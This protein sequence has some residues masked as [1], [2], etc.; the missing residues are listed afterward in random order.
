MKQITINLYSFEELSEEAKEKAIN[1]YREVSE[2]D[3]FH[4]LTSE[5]M[6]TIEKGLNQ[7]NCSLE[8]W[9]IDF[10]DANRS[11]FKVGINIDNEQSVLDFKPVRLRTWLLNNF[12][13]NFYARKPQG[14]Y[15]Q[16]GEAKKWAYSR[17]SK[18]IKKETDCPFTGVCY[19]YNFLDGLRKFLIK[20]DRSD[21]KELM[22]DAVFNVIRSVESEIQYK[23]S[24]K[25]IEE[26]IKNNEYTFEEDGTLNN[27]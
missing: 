13:S 10:Q 27:G 12:Y 1:E 22:Q 25:G 14:V 11:E 20:P 21:F 4:Y 18:I 2:T 3:G 19:D 7:F 9:S 23:L 26:E 6:A 5:A 17:Y 24:D 8:N 15:K 16:R